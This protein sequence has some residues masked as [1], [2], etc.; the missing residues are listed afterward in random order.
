MKQTTTVRRLLRF[1]ALL[2]PLTALAGSLAISP[3]MPPE[4]L[5]LARYIASLQERDPFTESGPV[6]V[7]IDAS[8]S[9]LHQQSRLVAV[10]QTD[11]SE[12]IAYRVLETEGDAAVT[13]DV[14]APCLAAE[15][16]LEGQPLSSILIT[17]ANYTFRYMGE[18][19]S[20][21]A[22]A[23]VFRIRPKKN[24]YGLIRG[25]LWID[26]VTGAAVM[27]A[28]YFVKTSSPFVHRIEIVRDTQLQNGHPCVRITRVR[29]E[30]RREGRGYMTMTEFA[31][32]A[33]AERSDIAIASSR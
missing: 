15:R 24:R 2:T 1:I 25:Q 8:L 19:A 5:A 6:E 14:I 4:S 17:P 13:R 22:S 30:T 18:F 9:G 23:Y 21:G 11:D 27:Q 20:G 26:S 3:P 7:T 29:L 10:R 32:A 33:A 31:P 16:Q 12:R 28:G